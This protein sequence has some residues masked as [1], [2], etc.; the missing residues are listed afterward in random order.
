[1]NW[2][3]KKILITGG[4]G[5]VGSHVVDFLL[6]KCGVSS[7]QIVIPD[8][9]KYD[10][11]IFSN[12]KEIIRG[13]DIVLHLAADVGGIGYS[14]THPASQMRNCLLLDLNIFEAAA[15]EKVEK[16]VCV[17]SAVAYPQDVPSPLKEEN[18]FN[19]SPAQG[20]YGYGFAKRMAVVLTKA[21]HEEKDLNACVLLSA[22]SYGPRQDFSL[23]TGH[24]IPSLI[25]KCLT[26]KTLE[27]WG[28]GKQI[29]DFFYVK[30][31]AKAVVL[32][33]ENLDTAEPINIG[34]G[35]SY[36]IK[37]LVDLISKLA[38]FK[39]KIFYDK[40]KPEGQKIRTVNIEKAREVLGFKPDY[41]LK[42]G[43]KETIEWFKIYGQ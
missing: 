18:L 35:K 36:T 4:R 6:D 22:N 15:L 11:R 40:S 5:F 41:S 12:A 29:R 7:S 10:L 33:A 25:R 28:D 23:D 20:G 32:A 3:K 31:F 38:N 30:D 17:S 26:Q 1:M 42:E 9:K 13:I 19:G 43:L 37:N 39:G 27:V 24:V 21:Y 14:S 8:S 16:L 34:S 2:K